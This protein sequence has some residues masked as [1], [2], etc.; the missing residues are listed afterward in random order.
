M[1]PVLRIALG[2]VLLGYLATLGSTA[3]AAAMIKSQAPC[4]TVNGYCLSF[5][6]ASSIPI[7]RS[8][9]FT[10]PSAGTASV[11]FHGSMICSNTGDDSRVVDLTSQIVPKSTLAPDPNGP[12]GLRH[13]IVLFS[14]TVGTSDSFS[15]ASTR[16]FN[17]AGAGPHNFH[18]KM[19]KLR[20]DAN[21]SC[22][23]YNAA[24]SV[25]FIP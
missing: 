25:L 11:T 9:K 14:R 5:S 19:Q 20:M 1:G 21:T 18:F 6:S 17:I 10:A 13:A 15:L 22:Y 24:F 2:F 12:G 3:S 4:V 7:I 8:I 23:V 16:D